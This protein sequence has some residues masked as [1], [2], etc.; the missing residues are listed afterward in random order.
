ML[1]VNYILSPNVTGKVTIHSH[2][3]ISMNDLFP[4][5]QT[6]LEVNGL[7][8]VKDGTVYKIIPVDQAK[9]QPLS[10]Q[11]G[12]DVKLQTDSSFVTQVIPFEYVKASDIVNIMRNLM[13][14]GA[15]IIVYEPSNILIVTALRPTN[16]IYKDS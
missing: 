4:V 3:K 13:P 14:R 16:E 9:Q 7:T 6:I 12:K 10:V 2:K 5:F 8:A 1:G 11:P 15:D